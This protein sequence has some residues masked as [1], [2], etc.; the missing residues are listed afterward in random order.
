MELSL[1]SDAEQRARDRVT[2]DA[3]GKPL[4]PSAFVDREARLRAHPWSRAALSSWQ[5]RAADGQLLSTCETY[6]MASA[7]LGRPGTTLGV[8]SVYTEGALRGRGYATRM[9]ELL[10][11]RLGAEAAPPQAL[12]LFSDVGAP[13]YERLGYRKR[14]AWDRVFAPLPGPAGAAADR[15]F[16]EQELPAR[17]AGVTSPDDELLIW[18]TASQLDWHLERE[19]AYAA[20]L[21]RPRPRACGAQAA[22]GVAVWAGDLAKRR[23]LVLALRAGGP[24]EAAALVEAARR[25]AA[26]A[27][28]EEVRIWEDAA[29][30][31]LLPAGGERVAREG[32]LPM[33]RPLDPAA[34]A[35]AW[36]AVPRGVWV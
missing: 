25:A 35:E 11:E 24:D 14:P 13:I 30:G 26:A 27:E 19:R 20:L 5:L 12:I 34:R 17:W 21:G 3:W 10:A 18:P 32:S 22:G 29:T 6:R 28:L 23:L 9:L 1:A 2:W 33:I 8:A 31:A 36:Q 15:L 16:G 7:V 4:S